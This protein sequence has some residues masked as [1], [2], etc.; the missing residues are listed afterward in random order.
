MVVKPAISSVVGPATGYDCESEE[1]FVPDMQLHIELAN[2]RSK[3][4]RAVQWVRGI[5]V[6]VFF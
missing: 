6:C 3:W 5:T 1:K 4:W 2:V